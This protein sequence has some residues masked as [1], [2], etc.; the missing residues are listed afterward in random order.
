MVKSTKQV[1]ILK[2]GLFDK[3]MQKILD[4]FKTKHGFN[5]SHDQVCESIATAVEQ[6]KLFN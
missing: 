4:Q 2:D 5:P 6:K 1:R 3:L